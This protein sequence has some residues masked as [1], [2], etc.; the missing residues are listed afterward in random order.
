MRILMTYENLVPLSQADAEQFVNNAIALS[1]RGHHVDFLIPKK[2]D[3]AR[4]AR[5]EV[6]EYYQVE[7]P[8]HI[9]ELSSVTWS[10]GAQHVNHALTVPKDPRF[11]AADLVY[12]RNLGMATMCLANGQRVLYEH[13][14]PWGDQFPP[15]Q[16]WLRHV[17]THPGFL[18]MVLHSDYA[19]QSY[20]RLGVPEKRLRV[21][22][23]GFEPRRMEPRLTQEAAREKLGLPKH[24]RI[25]MYTGRM[26]G[27]KGLDIALEMA[28]RLPEHLF[29]LVGSTGEGPDER[30][31]A[32]IPNVRIFPWQR[33]ADTAPFLYA[34]DVLL[35][36]P[37]AAPL[38]E[39]G[40]TVLPIKL[41]IYLAAGRPILAADNPDIHE[42][43][44]PG[45]NA[46]LVKPGDV[47]AATR[48]V[49]ALLRDP[50]RLERL[51]EGAGR[52]ADSLTWDAR[53][54]SVEAFMIE[55][56]ADTQ[57][58]D[59]DTAP[60]AWSG[61]RCLRETGEWL[62]GFPRGRF[63]RNPLAYAASARRL[64]P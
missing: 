19:K 54:A 21:C 45:E 49:D 16:L 31:A 27:K 29:V 18:G 40:N 14:R 37:S 28:R 52:T 2:P 7:G 42:I 34:A 41:F 1:R 24:G 10:L 15:M 12:T 58:A 47:D 8:L 22:H 64:A 25:V 3:R 4:D 30:A 23:N 61:T 44:R 32:H 36:P 46:V 5:A 43:L 17:M 51:G 48:E 26:N 56:M 50:V 39:H 38:L 6:L 60:I 55:R 62:A 11:R 63:V 59:E 57:R 33:F 9:D 35:V 13:Y 53:A 20:L